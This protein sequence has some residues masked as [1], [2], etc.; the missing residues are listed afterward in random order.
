MYKV[1]FVTQESRGILK[2]GGLGEVIYN[3]AYNLRKYSIESTILMPSH[4]ILRDPEVKKKLK[5]EKLSENSSKD[6]IIYRGELDNINLLLIGDSGEIL[7]MPV[8]YG[9]GITERKVAKITSNVLWVLDEAFKNGFQKPDIIHVNDWHGIPI[10]IGIKQAFEKNH[11]K[12]GSLMQI[13]LLV[14]KTVSWNYLIDDCNLDPFFKFTVYDGI[15]HKQLGLSEIYRYSNGVL[16]KMGAYIFDRIATVSNTYLR[17]DEGCVLNSLGWNFE[18]KSTFIYNGT[19]W[20]CKRILENVIGRQWDRISK[21][22]NKRRKSDVSRDDLRRYLLVCALGNLP[23]DEPVIKDEYLRNIVYS[24][25][26]PIIK[27]RGRPLGFSSDGPLVITTGRVSF[28][29][30]FDVLLKAIPRVIEVFPQ[31]RFLFLL[32]PV[33]GEERLIREIFE[34]AKKYPDNVRVVYG[35]ARSIYQLAHISADIFVAPSRWEPFGIMAIE[36]LATGNP[37]IASRVGGLSEIIIDLKEDINNGVGFLVNKEDSNELSEALV[38][39]LLLMIY[40]NTDDSGRAKINK[41][42]DK[43]D[44][45]YRRVVKEL[46]SK[47]NIYDVI[48]ERCIKRVDSRFRW[49]HSSQTA[50]RIYNEILSSED[51]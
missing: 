11:E 30:G 29:K 36:A 21:F 38:S 37:V 45:S 28:Q 32:L 42:I 26:G 1:W 10:G 43:L 48:R 5:I 16:E 51:I 44:P 9:E 33:R 46:L 50:F 40:G 27:E 20:E 47:E 35:I 13:H 24:L 19:D 39:L 6:V 3:L 49:S 22:T 23:K 41:L 12:I 15:F 8:V 7:D 34:E 31:T 2:V 4:G 25:R 17:H 14:G 18:K